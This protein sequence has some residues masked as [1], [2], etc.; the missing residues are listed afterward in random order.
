MRKSTAVAWA[1]SFGVLASLM[2][3][4]IGAEGVTWRRD[5]V[6]QWERAAMER[7]LGKEIADQMQQRPIVGGTKAPAGKW[8][9]Q[10]ALLDAK[11]AN[12]YN[13]Q[14]CGGAL[15]DKLFVVTAAH[16]VFG[17]HPADIHVLTGTQSLASGGTR[18]KVAAIKVHPSYKNSTTDYDIAVIKLQTPAT[19]LAVS[20]LIDKTQEASLASAG[21]NSTVIGWG[22]LK[23]NGDSYPKVLYQV[24][25][26][27]VSL[28]DCNDRNSYRGEITARM[29][30]AGLP[31][32]GKDSCDGDSGGPLV[33]KDSQGQWR[34]QAGIVSWGDGCARPNFY[35]VYSRV[36][37]L[38]AWANGIIAGLS[39]AQSSA[40]CEI[41]S[42]PDQLS[43]LD[44]AIA[45][46]EREMRSF[47]DTLRTGS[48]SLAIAAFE[49][50]HR[51]WSN[52]LESLC[53]FDAA[54]RGALGAK[55]CLLK[56]MEKR[57]ATL[58]EK[59]SLVAE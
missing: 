2:A 34:L 10:V 56:E 12:N 58:A 40:D 38:S 36:A 16:C 32:G 4:A 25:V 11:V 44:A 15:V 7:A 29:I 18:R 50:G 41:L 26:P 14:F 9:F 49:T 35:G 43:C 45:A 53:A 1:V 42:G 13:A 52:S 27:L 33:V 23:E 17:S 28:T 5:Y 47:L 59:L 37:V 21:T 46:N 3:P 6:R 31:A 20:K 54:S 24:V 55:S 39:P 48:A 30:C 51:A 8:P 19:G 57:A 22:D